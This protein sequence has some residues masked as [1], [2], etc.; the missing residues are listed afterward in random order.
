MQHSRVR[1][2]VA[3]TTARRERL[4]GETRFYACKPVKKETKD[5]AVPCLF[6]FIIRCASGREDPGLPVLYRKSRR[7][8]DLR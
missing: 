3:D 4:A 1:K 5:T 8:W 6:L 7:V 2:Y